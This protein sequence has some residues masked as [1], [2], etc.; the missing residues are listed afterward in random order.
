MLEA[1][2]TRVLAEVAWAKKTYPQI[3]APEAALAVRQCITKGAFGELRAAC[4]RQGS[5]L[6]GDFLALECEI[7][8]FALQCE[9]RYSSTAWPDDPSG[10]DRRSGRTIRLD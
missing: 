6:T 8:N 7:D 9:D 1:A 3:L 4:V 10:Q 5:P 2:M